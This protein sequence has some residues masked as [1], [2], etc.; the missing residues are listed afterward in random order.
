MARKEKKYHFVYKTT[1]IRNNNFYI[2]VHST[3]N[4][5]DGYVGSGKRIRN[6]KNRYGKNILSVEILEYLPDRE[7][8]MIRESEIINSDLLRNEKC[9]NLH[10]GGKGGFSH[11]TQIKN[12]P[13][14]HVKLRELK[15]D[16]IFFNKYRKNVGEGVKRGLIKR[17]KNGYWE[18]KKHSEETKNK[19]RKS[20]NVGINNPQYGTCW[21]TNGNEN[22][23]IYKGD[24]IPDSW[25]LG[26]TIKR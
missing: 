24:K 2:G 7:S 1:D 18:G 5:N 22:K 17:N 10:L 26:R 21:I 19:M 8:L 9:M 15:K 23:K 6:L 4:L 20:K 14:G 25:K 11:E 12:S 13:K 3:N 16:P